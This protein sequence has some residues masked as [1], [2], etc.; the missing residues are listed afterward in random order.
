[1][2]SDKNPLEFF[3]KMKKKPALQAILDNLDNYSVE[4]LENIHGQPLWIRNCLV[5]LKT[6]DLIF[7][8]DNAQEIAA[9]MS[10]PEQDDQRDLKKYEAR[11]WIGS[12]WDMP[13]G[14]SGGMTIVVNTGDLFFVWG[15][16]KVQLSSSISRLNHQQWNYFV[17]NSEHIDFMTKV[18]FADY[19]SKQLSGKMPAEQ[20]QAVQDF[21]NNQA[22]TVKNSDQGFAIVR[23]G[24]TYGGETK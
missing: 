4:E 15:Q 3:Y 7:T 21:V 20:S 17:N 6:P 11:R 16:G 18:D 5:Q 13:C 10:P 8:D 24:I 14:V 1:M 19:Q 2:R 23:H 22:S 12:D 9:M